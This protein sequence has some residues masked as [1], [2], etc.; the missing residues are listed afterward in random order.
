MPLWPSQ[1]LE[2]PNNPNN[3]WF[4]QLK[5]N[6]TNSTFDAAMDF[7]VDITYY[8]EWYQRVAYSTRI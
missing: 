6:R 4:W 8:T 2:I 1:S 5:I 7:I 3:V